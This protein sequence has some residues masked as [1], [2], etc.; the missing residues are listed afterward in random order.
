MERKIGEYEKNNIKN[1]LLK[2]NFEF[3]SLKN[4][5]IL[6]L[7]D[8][9]IITVDFMEETDEFCEVFVKYCGEEQSN[10]ALS[11]TNEIYDLI[12]LIN[13]YTIKEEDPLMNTEEIIFM[14]FNIMKKSEKDIEVVKIQYPKLNHFQNS[15]LLVF[16]ENFIKIAV[17]L[18]YNDS[19]MG[20]EIIDSYIRSFIHNG[21]IESDP[22]LVNFISYY[23]NNL[24]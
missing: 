16:V 11:N 22:R 14:L 17:L 21:Y 20:N 2:M 24:P 13:I 1:M 3:D 12:D 19:C 6:S 18:E 5:C 8:S 10:W 15:E 23:Y 9:T 7:K 4:I